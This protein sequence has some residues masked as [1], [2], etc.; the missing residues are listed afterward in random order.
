[1]LASLLICRECLRAFWHKLFLHFQ[2]EWEKGELKTNV[3]LSCFITRLPQ[4]TTHPVNQINR[5]T[6]TAAVTHLHHMSRTG[7][8]P[9]LNLTQRSLNQC[10]ATFKKLESTSC[11]Q[12]VCSERYSS[13]CASKLTALLMESSQ[14]GAETWGTSKWENSTSLKPIC[15]KDPP[16]VGFKAHSE[17]L[18]SHLGLL[19]SSFQ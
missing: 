10:R 19:R 1:M 13:R 4:P 14:C 5:C 7:L 6:L 12:R 2:S 16:Q 15:G 17:S 11:S 8:C 18:N 3:K 9:E